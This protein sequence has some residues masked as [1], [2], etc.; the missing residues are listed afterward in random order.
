M[1]NVAIQT[2]HFNEQA[3]SVDVCVYSRTSFVCFWK[4]KK[5]GK[6]HTIRSVN[7]HSK[8]TKPLRSFA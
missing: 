7:V 3:L 5:R 8:F 1:D 4:K 2:P 6:K